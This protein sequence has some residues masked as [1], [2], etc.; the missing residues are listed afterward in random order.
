MCVC[1]CVCVQ[2]KTPTP[3]TVLS[4]TPCKIYKPTSVDF[5]TQTGI[6]KCPFTRSTLRLAV[7]HSNNLLITLS[8]TGGWQ[9][10][11]QWQAQHNGGE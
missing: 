10:T 3:R 2:A 11:A 7:A 4:H 9:M 6:Q 8:M 1:V 5:K